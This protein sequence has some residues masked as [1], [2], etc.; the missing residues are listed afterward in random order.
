MIRCFKGS[1][2][3]LILINLGLS[4]YLIINQCFNNKCKEENILFNNLKDIYK[5]IQQK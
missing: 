5:L 2:L 3:K 1:F 4:I